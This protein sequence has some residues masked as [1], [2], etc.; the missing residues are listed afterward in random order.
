[1]YRETMIM[2]E[3]RRQL[4]DLK[5]DFLNVGIMDMVETAYQEY[6]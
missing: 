6:K 4:D 2:S 3:R 5:L 1:M